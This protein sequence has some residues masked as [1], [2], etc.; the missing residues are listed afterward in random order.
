MLWRPSA[1]G[2]GYELESPAAVAARLSR[3]FPFDLVT[4]QYFTMIFGVLDLRSH[5]LTYVTAGHPNLIHLPGGQ[6]AR[7]LE[8]SGYPVGVSDEAY[9]EYHVRLEPGDRLLAYSDGLTEAL[10]PEQDLFGQDRVV[11][12]LDA[13]RARSIAS[14]LSDLSGRVDEWTGPEVRQDDLSML[15]LERT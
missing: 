9:E 4:S 1:E 2:S 14:I 8:S 3:R 12:A 11:E 13:A 15:M 10:G 7:V 6:R 5:V